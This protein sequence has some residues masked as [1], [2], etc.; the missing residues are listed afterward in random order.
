MHDNRKDGTSVLLALF[1]RN[2]S[3]AERNYSVFEK[4]SLAVFA[5]TQKFGRYIE[6]SQ[7]VIFTDHKPII[8][9]FRKTAD[10]YS[11]QSRQFSF[12]S[13]FID[14]IVHISGDSNVVADCLSRPDNEE[15]ST[16]QPKF[17]SAVTC[18]PF[19]LQS[20]AKAQTSEFKNK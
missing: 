2:L 7:S 18:D 5:A 9:S 3:V 8:T 20:I 16:D 12:L 14:D 19:N 10:H 6:G 17:I 15:V 1:S 11:I 4:E 13:E